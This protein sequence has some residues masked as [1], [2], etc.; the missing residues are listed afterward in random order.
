MRAH[1]LFS[2]INGDDQD[3][4]Y[5]FQDHFLAFSRLQDH[6]QIGLGP[7]QAHS[8]DYDFD[9]SHKRL[10]HCGNPNIE[11]NR[12]S[13]SAAPIYSYILGKCEKPDTFLLATVAAGRLTQ[14]TAALALT[15]SLSFTHTRTLPVV[16]RRCRRR[17][18]CR[19]AAHS[20]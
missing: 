8:Y 18:H 20:N 12:N 19:R 11:A 3:R 2:S 7:E 6:Y 4:F 16:L 1:P 15:H 14:N 9:R 5:H 17:R 10:L 13:V